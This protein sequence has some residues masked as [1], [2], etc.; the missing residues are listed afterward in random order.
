[1]GDEAQPDADT[2]ALCLL[3]SEN[4]P[5]RIRTCDL[6]IRSPAL[7]PAE[8]RALGGRV[9]HIETDGLYVTCGNIVQ[10]VFARQYTGSLLRI[11]HWQP[12]SHD[13][14][15]NDWLM[16]VSRAVSRYLVTGGISLVV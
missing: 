16:I 14:A 9:S 6:R 3:L 13:S 7:Y 15:R 5:G 8:L 4:A 10:V 12:P 11:A 2:S 1:M